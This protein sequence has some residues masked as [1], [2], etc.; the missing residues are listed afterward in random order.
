MAN[1][2]KVQIP[3]ILKQPIIQRMILFVVAFVLISG[4]SGSW[5]IATRRLL[6]PFYFS[7]YG[8]AGKSLLFALV[9]FFLLTKRRIFEIPVEKW[10]ISH[11]LLAV[12][13]AASLGMFFVLA[14]QLLRFSH[15]SD[16]PAIA[17]LTHVAL[18]LSGVF[19]TGAI[20]GWSFLWTICQ[21]FWKETINSV[22]LGV[23]FYFLFGFIFMLWPYLSGMVLVAVSFLLRLTISNIVIV[24]PLTIQLPQFAITVGEYCSGIESIFLITTLYVLIGCLEHE[25]IKLFRFIVLYPPLII[26]MFCLNIGRVYAIILSGLVFGPEIAAKLF[27]TYLGMILFM[28]YFFI[29]WKLAAPIL[30]Q[31]RQTVGKGKL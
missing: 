19:I 15:F 14:N 8:S 9:T 23:I 25:R 1:P 16:A 6:F 10:R 2:A 22:A 27:H 4:V 20:F 31:T 7:I 17:L 29:F 26:G 24:P 30:I 5:L 11:A 12:G 18:I 28:I 21:R 3:A 13:S